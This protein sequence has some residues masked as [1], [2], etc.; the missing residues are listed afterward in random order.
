MPAPAPFDYVPAK[1]GRDSAQ[2]ASAF[3]YIWNCCCLAQQPIQAQR[4][5]RRQN[6]LHARC[7]KG[8]NDQIV[9]QLRPVPARDSPG[10][11]N[12]SKRCAQAWQ[13]REEIVGK[14]VEDEQPRRVSLRLV[15]EE[16]RHRRQVVSQRFGHTGHLGRSNEE[17]VQARARRCGRRGYPGCWLRGPRSEPVARPGRR[18][19]ARAS[20]RRTRRRPPARISQPTHPR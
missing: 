19:T 12:R 15:A 18:S 17:T 5:Q 2:G 13:A 9:G 14:R 16:L 20:V 10:A 3:G 8:G 4:R 1:N 7:R 11:R 6:H